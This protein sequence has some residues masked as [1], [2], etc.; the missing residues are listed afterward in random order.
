V[1]RGDHPLPITLRRLT[2]GDLDWVHGYISDLDLIRYMTMPL[3]SSLEASREC[4]QG[5]M[6]ESAETTWRCYS[7]AIVDASSD[8]A[9]G[10]CGVVVL[11]GVEQ[12]EIWYLVGREHW[13]R[14]VATEATRQ[15]LRLGFV[16]LELHRLWATCLPNNVASLRVLEKAGLRREGY[17][18]KSQKVHGVWEDAFLY[19]ILREEWAT[20]HPREP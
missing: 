11:P 2:T 17:Q 14:G 20:A 8:G 4:L 7:R 19:A 13:G 16:E 18:H 12:G 10:M 15:L 3:S 5:L 6:N 9:V 1:K